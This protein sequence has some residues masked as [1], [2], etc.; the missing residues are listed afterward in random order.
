MTVT[1]RVVGVLGALAIVTLV[2]AGIA[3][4]ERP[5]PFMHELDAAATRSR[6]SGSYEAVPPGSP[7]DAAGGCTPLPPVLE[8]TPPRATLEIDVGPP[9]GASQVA[10]AAFLLGPGEPFALGPLAPAGN[11]MRLVYDEAVDLTAYDALVVHAQAGAPAEAPS[12]PRIF[13]IEIGAGPAD[14][15]AAWDDETL[16]PLPAARGSVRL[17]QIG[18]VEISAVAIGTATGL[19]PFPGLVYRAWLHG[20]D[21]DT[22]LGELEPVDTHAGE[23]ALG[24]RV[25]RVRLSAADRVLVTLEPAGASPAAPAGVPVLESAV[26]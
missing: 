16:P 13:H 9:A 4:Q 26:R 14:R 7:V 11:T 3:L 22:L 6:V 23:A 17:N 5:G 18:A 21:G 10:L 19:T 24:A 25:E 15:R 20:P 8:C 12:G 1:D 2:V